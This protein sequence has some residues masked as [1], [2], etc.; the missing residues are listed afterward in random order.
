MLVTPSFFCLCVLPHPVTHVLPSLPVWISVTLLSVVCSDGRPFSST[1]LLA[2]FRVTVAPPL[3]VI[4]AV[5]PVS[6]VTCSHG[7]G[8]GAGVTG[9][10]VA[11]IEGL[12]G[13]R[14]I[15]QVGEVKYRAATGRS[16]PYDSTIAC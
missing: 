7:T 11:K 12:A 6:V 1:L 3:T 15:R 13:Q 14:N 10:A 2:G 16:S 4:C 5:F 9:G 8:G